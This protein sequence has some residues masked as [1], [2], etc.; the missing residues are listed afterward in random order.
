M[1]SSF[2]F[3]FA[4]VKAM[5]AA[6]KDKPKNHIGEHYKGLFLVR[7]KSKSGISHWQQG[8]DPMV[9]MG[10]FKGCLGL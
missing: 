1:T 7:V 6:V 9:S 8:L 2:T 3:G 4:L 10:H 5:L